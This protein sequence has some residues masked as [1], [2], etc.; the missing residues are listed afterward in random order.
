MAQ[1]AYMDSLFALA[2]AGDP[3]GLYSHARLAERMSHREAIEVADGLVG[4]GA[5]SFAGLGY[6]VHPY[7]GWAVLPERRAAIPAE[8]RRRVMARDGHACVECGATDDL[9]LDHIFPWSLGGPDT[10]ENLRVLCRSCNSSK[11]ARV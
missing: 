2:D 11:G 6:L 7:C 10:E 4:I 9:A 3:N 8:L 1:W 5:W